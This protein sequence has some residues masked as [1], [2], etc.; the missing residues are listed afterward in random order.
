MRRVV[1]MLLA[2]IVACAPARAADIAVG[3][4]A[5]AS[6]ADPHFHELTPN[7][8]LARHVFG[9]L[10]RTDRDLKPQPDLAASWT[11]VDD[12]TWMFTLRP[13]VKFHDGTPFTADDVVFSLCRAR[14][15]VGPTQSFTRVPRLIDRADVPDPNTLILHTV[16]PYPLL[17]QDL[18][19]FAIISAH[20]AGVIAPKFTATGACGLTDL[21]VSTEFDGGRMANGTGPYRLAHYVSG[22]VAVL[23]GDPGYHGAKPHWNRVTMKPVPRSGARLAG[24]LSGDFDLIE[25]PS[26]QDLPILKQRGGFASV[27][28]PSDRIIFLQPD[29]GREHSP[30]AAGPDHLNPLRDARVREAISLAID[31]RAI[32]GR[33]MDG[34]AVPADQYLAPGLAG[35]LPKPP[36]RGFD[37]QRARALLAEAGYPDGFTLTLSATSDRYI[38][39]AQVAQALGQYLTRIGIKVSVDAMTQT[40]FFP[41][42]AKREFSLAM[43]GWGFDDPSS[44]LRTWIVST[45][46]ARALGQS[47]YGAYHNAALDALVIPA[48]EDMDAARRQDRLMQATEIALRDNAIIPLYWET[49][50]WAFK[51]RYSYA[52]RLDQLTDVDGLQP[53]EN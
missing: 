22:E 45:D 21:P 28:T 41:H 29:I 5:A 32:A 52:G 7:N 39:D 6:S 20:S 44:M 24:L 9:A 10:L 17:A 50:A 40:V 36:P 33:L 4:A 8:T 31:R 37:P 34:M 26:A 27:V 30:L 25:S 12:R 38:N 18:A 48:L 43:G 51:D 42:R 14:P 49:T 13:D 23:E 15:G 35:T 3:L 53:K 11:L 47:N 19:A 46:Q 2:G 16:Q 1:P